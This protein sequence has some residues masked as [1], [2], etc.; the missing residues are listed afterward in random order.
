MALAFGVSRPAATEFSFL[1][2]IPTLMAAGAFK[3]LSA[4]KDG[5]AGNEDWGMVA[6]G[7]VVSAIFAFIVVKWLIR[8]VQGHTFNGFAWYRIALGSAL[9]IW[10]YNGGGN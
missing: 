5:E 1:L 8:F 3:I 2:G 10:V 9:L 4:I 7:T 6:L